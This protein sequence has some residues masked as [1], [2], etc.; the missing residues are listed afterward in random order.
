M[1]KQQRHTKKSVGLEEISQK[2]PISPVDPYRNIV[3]TTIVSR[4]GEVVVVMETYC[5]QQRRLRQRQQR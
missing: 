3:G 4:Y 5:W 2:R 1:M